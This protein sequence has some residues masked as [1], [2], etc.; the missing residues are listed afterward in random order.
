MSVK[1]RAYFVY[2]PESLADLRR[3]HRP[4]EERPYADIPY[5]V[6]RSDAHRALNLRAAEQT[7]VLLEN[8]DGFLPLDT[9]CLCSTTSSTRCVMIAMHIVGALGKAAL[10]RP[11]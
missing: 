2:R 5:A 7:L 11:M 3:P 9:S 4:E 8:K 6:L 1:G 10:T